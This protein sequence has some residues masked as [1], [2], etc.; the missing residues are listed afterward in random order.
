MVIDIVLGIVI[1][2]IWIFTISYLVFTIMG[3]ITRKVGK[4]WQSGKLEAE[5]EYKK[6]GN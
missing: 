6:K 1:G 4:N 3:S 2:A 5:E